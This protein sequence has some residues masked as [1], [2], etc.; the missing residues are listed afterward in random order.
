MLI[1][2]Y[3][4]GKVSPS[5]KIKNLDW[6]D[7]LCKKIAKASGL[8]IENLDPVGTQKFLKLDQNDPQMIYGV[9]AYLIA[10]ADLVIVNLTDDI[11]VG[12]SQE[13]LIAKHFEKP[14]IGLLRRH[15]KF[16]KNNWIHPFVAVPCDYLA[17]SENELS[18]VVTKIVKEQISTK[19]I[20]VINRATNY[21]LN[22]QG[23]KTDLVRQNLK[24]YSA[25]KALVR[26]HDK[27]LIIKQK[28]SNKFYWDLPGGIVKFG[29]SPLQALKRESKEEV[30]LELSVSGHL[31]V[32]SFFR[33]DGDQ[34]V[35]ATF[36]CDTRDTKVN[37]RNNP[38]SPAEKI[39]DFAWVTKS[40]FMSR[41][42]GV[43][44][45]SL[46]DLVKNFY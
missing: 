28:I 17:F 12:G 34:V 44:D 32:W 1:K 27:F 30:G 2:V 22:F 35:C 20:D 21:F 13:M 33:N 40:Q 43:Y 25:V 23:L 9:D 38:E 29:E 14:L 6:R 8:E 7:R 24:V 42:F 5:K 37:I 16:H 31:G 15:G 45:D 11:S 4:A 18:Q 41:K 36:V 26:H 10:N 46:K 3:L 19:N 39:V